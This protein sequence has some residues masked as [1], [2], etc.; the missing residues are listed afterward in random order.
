[1]A[2]KKAKKT[3]KNKKAKQAKP[4]SKKPAKKAS[5][6]KEEKTNIKIKDIDIEKDTKNLLWIIIGIIAVFALF[7]IIRFLIP[8]KD[9]MTVDKMHEL[10]MKGK[11]EDETAYVYNG[12]SFL[13]IDDVWYTQLQKGSTIFDVTVNYG[14]REVEDIPVEG[15]LE[16]DFIQADKFFITFDPEGEDLKYV[17]VANYGLSNSLVRAFG[18]DLTAGCLK[19]VTED[20]A[21]APIITCD[22]EDKNVFYFKEAEEAKVIFDS[23][24]VTIQG[25]GSDIVKAKDRLLLRWYN[26]LR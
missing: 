10:N 13:K 16:N 26:I 19:N 24:C 1:M 6:P 3:T 22:D 4:R 20:C 15:S 18:F 8:S 23:N 25:K 5:A 21:K 2:K 14:P 7:F 17:A 12:F 11:L 9:V